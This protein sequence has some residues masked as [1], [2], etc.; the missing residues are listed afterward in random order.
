[1]PLKSGL[2]FGSRG[3]GAFGS[4]FVTFALWADTEEG[5]T[6]T[7]QSTAAATIKLKR[8]GIDDP[9]SPRSVMASSFFADG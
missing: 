7:P 4:N 1:L 5:H 9:R 3:T 8:P 2:P 6:T